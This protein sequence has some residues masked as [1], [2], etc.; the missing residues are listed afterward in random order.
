LGRP[1]RSDAWAAAADPWWRWTRVM[2][3]DEGSQA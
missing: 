2:G 1:R 3:R